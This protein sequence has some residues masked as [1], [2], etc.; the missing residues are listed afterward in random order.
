MKITNLTKKYGD[1]CLFSNLDFEINQGIIEIK[2]PSGSGKTTLINIIM[3]IE[4]PTSGSVDL[5]P[6]QKTISYCGQAQSLFYDLSINQNIKVFNL[7]DEEIVKLHEL[8]SKL[9]LN[10]ESDKSLF[11]ASGGER[12]KAEIIFC[13]AKNANVYIFDEPFASLDKNSREILANYLISFTKNRIMILINHDSY[14]PSFMPNIEINMAL[15]GITSINENKIEEKTFVQEVLPQRKVKDK[16]LPLYLKNN[17]VD[18]LF[19]FLFSILCIL[20]FSLGLSFTNTKS[21][22]QKTQISLEADPFDV[23]GFELN[24]SDPIDSGFFSFSS[25]KGYESLMLRVKSTREKALFVGVLNEENEVKVYH[26][27][28]FHNI[29]NEAETISLNGETFASSLIDSDSDIIDLDF[30]YTLKSMIDGKS[31]VGSIIFTSKSFI[32]KLLVNNDFSSFSFEKEEIAFS[33]LPGLRYENNKC[34]VNYT[35]GGNIKITDENSD[36]SFAI[37]GISAPIQIN[38]INENN[39]YNIVEKLYVNNQI[40]DNDNEFEMSL[41]QYKDFLMHA[42]F[43]NTGDQFYYFSFADILFPEI[44]NYGSFKARNVINDYS[45][46]SINKALVYF[47]I[48]SSFFLGEIIYLVFSYKGKSRWA[49]DIIGVYQHNSINK[50]IVHKRLLISCLLQT[51]P[52]AI[53]FIPLYAFLFIPIANYTNMVERFIS[54]PVGH[55]FYSQYPLNNYYE[56]IDSPIN[57]ITFENLYFAIFIIAIVIALV[58][59]FSLIDG[60]KRNNRKHV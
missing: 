14:L 1:R 31:D 26:P 57:F 50:Q 34:Y 30:D 48:S 54:Y 35:N 53:L 2:G 20:F 19:K 49:R 43:S 22:Y 3:G 18:F 21:D 12:Q 16:V 46:I 44:S 38:A 47:G 11:Y 52:L 51:L 56:S 8:K 4:E 10:Y 13:L 41:N 60:A 17:K 33:P 27:S 9:N 58:D 32:C 6:Y 7:S 29:F 59:Y 15:N 25:Y 5:P 40:S 37:S 39:N 28:N 23:H 55:Y 42:S 45:N 24:Q 36:Y